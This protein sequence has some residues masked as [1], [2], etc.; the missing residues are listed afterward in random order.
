MSIVPTLTREQAHELLSAAAETTILVVGDVMLDRYVWGDADRVSP[1]APVPVVGVRGRR[2]SLGGAANVAAGVRAL[3]GSCRVVGAVGEDRAGLSVGA[4]L[5]RAG[6]PADGLVA[7]DDRPTTRKTRI[8]A[9]NQQVLRV[10]REDDSPLDTEDA[11]RLLERALTEL[12]GADLLVLQ[13]YDKGVLTPAVAER[14]LTEAVGRGVPV[15]VDPKLRHFFDYPGAFVFKP[16]GRE[17]AAALGVERPPLDTERLRAVARRL[18]C[19]HL[20]LTRGPR[21]MCL[22]EEGAEEALHIPARSREV[23]D[24]SG[25]GDTVTAV[26]AATLATGAALRPAAVLANFAAG[27]AVSLLGA[28]PV[29][30]ETILDAFHDGLIEIEDDAGGGGSG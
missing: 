16:N 19:R 26:L 30:T 22:L 6:I 2:E 1:E 27:L 12:P 8:L 24:V 9:R 29:A 7:T 21:G 10:D 14:L 4:L 23:F 5:E 20:L 11:K 28:Q 18:D 15:I 17:L 13:D 3:G 25:A